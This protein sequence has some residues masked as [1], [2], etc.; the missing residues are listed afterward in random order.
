MYL[1]STKLVPGDTQK[2]LGEYKLRLKRAE[3]EI[4]TL[5]GNVCIVQ[6]YSVHKLFS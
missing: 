6:L 1:V 3:Q 5:E 2:E 4:T